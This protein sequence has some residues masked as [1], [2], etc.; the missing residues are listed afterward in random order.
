MKAVGTVEAIDFEGLRKYVLS[1][2]EYRD[3]LNDQEPTPMR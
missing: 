3:K 2:E 1:R